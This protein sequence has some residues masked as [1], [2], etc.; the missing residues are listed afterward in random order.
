MDLLRIPFYCKSMFYSKIVITFAYELG[1]RQNLYRFVSTE[2]LDLVQNSIAVFVKFKF[3][4]F[5]PED[6]FF[7]VLSSDVEIA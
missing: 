4:K 3:A 7:G 1:F 5:G 2:K 6:R